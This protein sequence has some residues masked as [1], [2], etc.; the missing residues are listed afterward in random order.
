MVGDPDQPE[1]FSMFDAVF[2]AAAVASFAV[3]AALVHGCERL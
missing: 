3:L 2:L 1:N